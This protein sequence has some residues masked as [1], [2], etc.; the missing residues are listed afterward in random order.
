MTSVSGWPERGLLDTA[1]TDT[2]DG[3]DLDVSL[4]SPRSTPGV[5]DEVVLLSVLGSVSDS[6]DGV[7]EGGSA[8][9]GVEDTT[10]VELE[11]GSVSL[12]GDGGWSLGNGSLELG[13]GSG[14]DVSVGL[15]LDLALG[16]RV[17]AGSVS[18]GVWVVGLELLSVR[19]GVLEGVSLPSTGASIGGSVAVDELLLGEGEESSGLDE[20]VSLNGGGGREGPA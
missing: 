3:S 15:D 6:G 7:I 17:L 5:S 13:D 20:V 10:V 4:I 19:L 18:S 16:G 2:V 14:L 8:G 12:N 11:D 1:D 9:G